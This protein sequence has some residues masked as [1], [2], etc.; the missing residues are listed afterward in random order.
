MFLTL[1]PNLDHIQEVGLFTAE[2]R[3][4]YDEIIGNLVLFLNKCLYK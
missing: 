1:F 2:E 4:A 3:L